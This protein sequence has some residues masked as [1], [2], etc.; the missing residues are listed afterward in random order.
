MKVTVYSQPQCVDCRK[1]KMFFNNYSIDFV[2]KDVK[3]DPDAMEEL[4][5]LGSRTLATVV[6]DEQ[7]FRGF[8]ENVYRIKEVLGLQ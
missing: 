5:K 1:A 4:K 7:V 2:E 3:A 6:I 8:S